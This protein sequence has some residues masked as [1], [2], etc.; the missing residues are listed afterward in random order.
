MKDIGAYVESKD[1]EL[2][3]T[4]TNFAR[5]QELWSMSDVVDGDGDNDEEEEEGEEEEEEEEEWRLTQSISANI[6][7][8]FHTTGTDGASLVHFI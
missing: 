2:G 4:L 3:L 6:S 8:T 7:Q 5:Y 1:F